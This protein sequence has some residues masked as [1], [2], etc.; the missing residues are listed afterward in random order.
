[1]AEDDVDVHD[2]HNV[3]DQFLAEDD[4]DV[5]DVENPIQ[6][7]DGD[8]QAINETGDEEVDEV[9]EDEE[10]DS[11]YNFET[12]SGESRPPGD[13]S[14]DDDLNAF[15]P[16]V[17]IGG[18]NDH[19]SVDELGEIGDDD[20]DDPSDVDNVEEFVEIDDYDTILKHL[21]RE[22]LKVELRHKVSK[23]ASNSLW[24]LGKAWFHRL[25]TTKQLQNVRKKTPAF[26]HIRRT[27]YKDLVPPVKMTIA[28]KHKESETITVVEDVL[29]T[30]KKQFPP[31][32]YKKLWEIS[33]VE[34][35]HNLFHP[36]LKFL[37]LPIFSFL[38]CSS[39]FCHCF[40][41]FFKVLHNKNTKYLKIADEKD[42]PG[43]IQILP[44]NSKKVVCRL[45]NKIML[46][47]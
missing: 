39:F 20:D 36:L 24:A 44:G 6:D 43:G 4:V 8:S 19:D 13:V 34:V 37:P 18:A 7:Q 26:P 3:Q 33:R 31:H 41:L 14:D 40:G 42:V 2:V 25:F 5:H 35:K 47:I 46:F 22:W 1:M 27:L 29:V 16:E 9:D 10:M 11:D 23:V 45:L 38:R 15:H 30:P 17:D 12:H 21:S 28:Y 32:Q